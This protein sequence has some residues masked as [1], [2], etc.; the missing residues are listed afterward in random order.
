ML[1]PSAA[2]AATHRIPFS[3]WF[4][5]VLILQ[6]SLLRSDGEGGEEQIGEAIPVQ[7]L[8]KGEV[9]PANGPLTG[10]WNSCES[11]LYIAFKASALM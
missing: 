3:S 4:A 1:P 11:F 2:A 10:T 9:P 8:V 7:Q 5:L 6:M